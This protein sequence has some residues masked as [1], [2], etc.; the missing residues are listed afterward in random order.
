M[1]WRSAKFTVG[2][3][4]VLVLPD[5][6]AP[7]AWSLRIKGSGNIKKIV[8]SECFSGQQ[9]F[10][11][12]AALGF[13]TDGSIYRKYLSNAYL[14]VVLRKG[15]IVRLG[16]NG[17]NAASVTMLREENA[18]VAWDA[19]VGEPYEERQRREEATDEGCV[20]GGKTAFREK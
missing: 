18:V 2:D 19:W 14:S 13:E 15:R 6:G 12:M 4:F 11:T 20:P 16:V 9:Q 5:E 1:M 3:K 8:Q 10:K 17:V 7:E